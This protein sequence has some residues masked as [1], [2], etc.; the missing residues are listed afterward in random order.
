MH[1]LR[2][3]LASLAFGA[4]AIWGSEVL[5]WSAPPVPLVPIDLAL[6]WI[7]YSGAAGLALGL[8]LRFGLGGWRGAF[9]GGAVLGFVAEGVI[10][11]TMYQAFPVQVV[12]TPLAWHALIT[13]GAVVWLARSGARRSVGRQALGWLLLGLFGGLWAQY[14][15]VERAM[16]GT[17][18]VGLYLVGT[19]L[20]VPLA[21]ILL[22]RLTPLH[23]PPA[24]ALRVLPILALALWLLGT[25]AAPS[26]VRLACPLLIVLTGWMVWRLGAP[27]PLAL[28]T[29]VAAWRHVLF[30]IAP[31]T[32]AILAG[33]AQAIGGLPVNVPVALASGALGLG[34]WLWLLACALRRRPQPPVAAS[35]S[36]S[37]NAPS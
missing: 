2:F 17:W 32:A 21:N 23:R 28:G 20:A 16:P 6:T 33:Q 3:L 26:P 13:G 7:A 35:A 4:I 30:L 37:S 19:G 9:L 25:M 10:V 1:G 12:W 24:W 27:G 14:W 8:V 15:P 31:L 29:P 34:L 18:D 11:G 5:F 22:D 36:A